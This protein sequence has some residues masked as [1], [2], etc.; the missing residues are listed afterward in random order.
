MMNPTRVFVSQ[1]FVEWLKWFLC[2]PGVESLIDEWSKSLTTNENEIIDYCHSKAWANFQSDSQNNLRKQYPHLDLAF[3][4]FVDWFNPLG[5]KCSGKQVSLG[6]LALTCLN[7][8]PSM[9]YKPQYTYLAGIIPAPNQPSMVTMNNVLK[10][11][12]NELIELNKTIRIQTYQEPEG[13]NV[14]VKLQALLGDVVA[15]HKVA[16]FT[17]HSGHKFCSWCEVI[18]ADIAKME[19]RKPQN[20]N[21]TKALAM[22]WHDEK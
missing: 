22:R 9:R 3:T 5:N 15:T 12:V 8:P 17:S 18:K 14:R 13:Q 1:S 10:P 16:G 19:I 4:L 6:V 7:L 11:L 20:K 21:S 2:I